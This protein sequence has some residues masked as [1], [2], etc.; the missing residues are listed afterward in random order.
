MS[1]SQRLLNRF[2]S[3]RAACT[4]H[5]PQ[6]ICEL[7]NYSCPALL[8]PPSNELWDMLKLKQSTGRGKKE[9]K[10]KTWVK[11]HIAVGSQVE[12][13]LINTAAAQNV[14]INN[15]IKNLTSNNSFKFFFFFKFQLIFI[16]RHIYKITFI[17]YRGRNMQ[18][19]EIRGGKKAPQ[20]Q[21]DVQRDR[22]TSAA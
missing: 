6:S 18:N 1:H 21:H 7:T 12:A 19:I 10:I 3:F 9:F 4:Q 16:Y 8:C 13:C 5:W 17:G 20:E 11:W 22:N 14:Y 2:F 15:K